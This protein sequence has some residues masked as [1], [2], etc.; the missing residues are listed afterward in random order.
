MYMK[1]LYLKYNT[2]ITQI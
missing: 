2:R 1:V